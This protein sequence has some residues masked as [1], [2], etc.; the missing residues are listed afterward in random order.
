MAKKVFSKTL[1]IRPEK[2]CA[3]TISP[4]LVLHDNDGSYTKKAD[5]ILRGSA[6][7]IS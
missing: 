7:Q 4:G 1:I 2:G 5:A 3:M 6:C